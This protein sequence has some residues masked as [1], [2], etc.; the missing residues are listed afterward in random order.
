MSDLPLVSICIITYNSADFILETLNSAKNQSYSNI[1]LIISDDASSDATVEVCK[2]WLEENANSFVRTELI[3]IKQNTGIPANCNR[4]VKTAQGKWIKLIAGDDILLPSCISDNIEY[5]THHPETQILFS[6]LKSFTVINGEKNFLDPVKLPQSFLSLDANQQFVEIIFGKMEGVTPTAFIAK[7][8]FE[9]LD[10][11]DEVYKLAED[12]PFWLKC[13][14]NGY[15]FVSMDKTTVLYRRHTNNTGVAKEANG[16][17][18]K[19]RM[20]IFRQYMNLINAN[21]NSKTAFAK[22]YKENYFYF[23]KFCNTSENLELLRNVNKTNKISNTFYFLAQR[24][25]S[26]FPKNTF[27]ARL[28]R[29]MYYRML[30]LLN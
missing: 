1:E 29:S 3:S 19:D 13:T 25:I 8:L 2:N 26:V 20:K 24:Y 16:T 17:L 6:A 30:M 28:L 7:G 10:Y 11:Y 21:E 14:T 15:R 5:I 9:K 12:Y 27:R 22:Y 18:F 4:A 23:I